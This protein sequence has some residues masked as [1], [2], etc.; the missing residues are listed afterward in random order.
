MK[1]TY[2]AQESVAPYG[3]VV[4][5]TTQDMDVCRGVMLSGAATGP[6]TLTVGGADVSVHMIKGHIYPI[7]CTKSSSAHIFHL[8]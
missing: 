8:Y 6:F 2:T 4:A 3:K 1:Q 7:A 5:S